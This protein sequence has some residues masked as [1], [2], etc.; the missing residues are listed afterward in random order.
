[1]QKDKYAIDGE[2]TTTSNL[3][4]HRTRQGRQERGR[5]FLIEHVASRTSTWH[6]R[7]LFTVGCICSVCLT[8]RQGQEYIYINDL[9]QHKKTAHD[10]DPNLHEC[11]SLHLS[12]ADKNKF[13]NKITVLSRGTSITSSP[14]V[15]TA[16]R[17][18]TALEFPQ[19]DPV[20]G[21]VRARMV[22]L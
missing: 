11:T 15:A 1:M 17:C 21:R 7:Y 8:D 6:G 14:A 9:S 4:E 20:W 22:D 19:Y 13:G 16:F 10:Y 12:G 2:M 18:D 3:V 5:A